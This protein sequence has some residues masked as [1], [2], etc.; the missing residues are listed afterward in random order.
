MPK[1][2]TRKSEDFDRW[3]TDTVRRAELA[4]YAPVRGCMVIRPYGYALWE[5]IQR[6]LDDMIKRTG[7]ENMYFP[8]L[9]PEFVPA[10]GGPARR[11]LRPRG[12]LGDPGGAAGAGGAAGDPADQ[13]DHHLLDVRGL[14]PQLPRP[15]GADQPVVQHPALGAAHPALPADHRVPLAGGPHLPREPRR[16]GRGGG[17][18][19]RLLPRARRGVALHPGGAGAQDG[20]RE[21][22]GRRVHALHRGDDER[23]LGAP[24]GDLPPARAELHPRLRDQLQRPGERAPASLPDVVGT[25]DPDHRRR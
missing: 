3:Y 13:R 12:G 2:I 7:H 18:D 15:A 5:R 9:I 25:V 23:R 22:R 14:D 24:G 20:V 17:P 11:G 19:A 1:A 6:A 4:D 8:L 16:G 10:E 21:V